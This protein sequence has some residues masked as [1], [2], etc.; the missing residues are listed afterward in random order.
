MAKR[1]IFTGPSPGPV[2]SRETVLRPINLI[3]LISP[4]A[5]NT[6]SPIRSS[7]ML[8]SPSGVF[9]R[10]PDRKQLI[11]L[12][13][14][15][16]VCADEL[17]PAKHNPNATPAPSFQPAIKLRRDVATV[18]FALAESSRE[19]TGE[20]I[21]RPPT[22]NGGPLYHWALFPNCNCDVTTVHSS[23]EAID[24]RGRLQL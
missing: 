9:I 22:L 5:V 20:L 1:E 10:V 13:G 7:S 15:S 18:A 2:R 16:K 21:S 24:H 3:G 6:V 23:A 19:L 4:E 14:V 12:V 8:I 11:F 17:R